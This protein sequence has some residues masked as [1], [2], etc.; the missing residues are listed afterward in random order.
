MIQTAY[1]TKDKI[2][3]ETITFFL[4]TVD[5][6]EEYRYCIRLV[7]LWKKSLPYSDKFL[8]SFKMLNSLNKNSEMVGLKEYGNICNKR[9]MKELYI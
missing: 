3:A 8:V 6:N 9:G 7:C 4:D 2:E 5:V 1:N